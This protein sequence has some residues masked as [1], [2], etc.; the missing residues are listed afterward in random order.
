MRAVVVERT[1]ILSAL[2][3]IGD[4]AY[5]GGAFGE[6]VHSVLE[7]AAYGVPVLCGPGIGRSRDAE[8]MHREGALFVVRDRSELRERV[9]QLAEE[10][11]RREEMGR[12][13]RA[14]VERRVGGSG[15]IIDSL[16]RRGLLPPL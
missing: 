8:Q 10:P 12:Q 15:R 9:R 5:V 14:F 2:Y 6:G 4:I 16:R 11:E 1:G 3:R 7:P 13:V